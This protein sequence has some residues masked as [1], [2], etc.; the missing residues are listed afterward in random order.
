MLGVFAAGPSGDYLISQNLVKGLWLSDG[1]R[2]RTHYDKALPAEIGF[3]AGWCQVSHLGR[4]L[5]GR[6]VDGFRLQKDRTTIRRT[7]VAISFP[8]IRND[9]KFRLV[10]SYPGLSSPDVPCFTPSCD[11]IASA[12]RHL[13]KLHRVDSSCGLRTCQYQPLGDLSHSESSLRLLAPAMHRAVPLSERSGPDLQQPL[14]LLFQVLAAPEDLLH[15]SPC[16]C[17][18]R[19]ELR[20]CPGKP[21]LQ[22][23]ETVQRAGTSRSAPEMTHQ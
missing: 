2:P 21:P 19:H 1:N 16:T 6:N 9:P 23:G 8:Q 5:Q 17:A 4:S 14:L 18:Q 3:P 10:P 12:C 20:S 13:L 22:G 15:P 7:G 11:V